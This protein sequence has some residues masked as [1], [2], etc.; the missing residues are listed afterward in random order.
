MIEAPYNSTITHH[1]LG[2]YTLAGSHIKNF[3]EFFHTLTE[4]PLLYGMHC[5]HS[6]V[7]GSIGT[8]INYYT[9]YW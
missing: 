5:Y 2:L 9:P 3:I 8:P 6:C 4:P 1:Y 7:T